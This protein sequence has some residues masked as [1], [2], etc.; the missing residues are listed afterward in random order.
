[1]QVISVIPIQKG[2]PFDTLT[3][4][5]H[6]PVPEGFL[7]QIP[8]Q[9]RQITG[10]AIESR[11]L[12]DAKLDVKSSAFSL[13]KISQIIGPSSID[14]I[15]LTAAKK[16][17]RRS[18]IP[19]GA[20]LGEI[21]VSATLEQRQYL[22]KE[23][24]AESKHQAPLFVQGD[25]AMRADDYRMLIRDALAG[26]QSVLFIA[27]TIGQ[28]EE[29]RAILAKGIEKRSF[30]LHS[31]VTKTE[32]KK[33]YRE[34]FQREG[35][36]ILFA[37]PH[38]AMI[39][40]LETP[41]TILD[42]LSHVGYLS[43]GSVPVDYQEF[44]RTIVAARNK[45]LVLGDRVIPFRY[46]WEEE[47]NPR[48]LFPRSYLPTKLHILDTSKRTFENISQEIVELLRHTD[49]TQ[50]KVFV[51]AERKGIAPYSVCRTCKMVIKCRHCAAS[52]VLRSV[53]GS[54]G[55]KER[56]FLCPE[57]GNQE[58]STYTCANCGSWDIEARES[59]S[60]GLFEAIKNLN[61][62][63]PTLLIEG[64]RE[65]DEDIKRALENAPRGA[66]IIG[67]D[68][69]FS[70]LRETDFSIIP[71]FDRL[72]S[73]MTL[74]AGERTLRLLYQLDEITTDRIILVTKNPTQSFLKALEKKELGKYVE[75][76]K[77][78]ARAL[79]YPP[80]GTMFKVSI[81]TPEHDRENAVESVIAACKPL[82]AFHVSSKRSRPGA[83]YVTL[84]FLVKAGRSFFESDTG[85]YERLV[86]ELS[87][88]PYRPNIEGNPDRVI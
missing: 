71:H 61:L 38:Y 45:K 42:N 11:S 25:S 16:V 41:I 58:P 22:T 66:V 68:R 17:A 30:V 27:P 32:Q 74:G 2:I 3:Y 6:D 60:E 35:A 24:S 5:S 55:K 21:L 75:E 26:H 85:H 62:S 73:K 77:E 67:T 48:S 18:F 49:V 14:R 36:F 1:M 13:K 70:F 69:A 64:E 12:S 28:V 72:L 59:G 7:V 50:K 80:F 4:Y 39:P 37:T 54:D 65:T 76:E 86:A 53:T 47:K 44:Y 23:S 31:D 43:H 81:R 9:S 88:L 46:V 78:V 51:Y 63:L 87:L 34:L 8:L 19:L 15:F 83:A 10:V 84:I 29:W 82:E 40:W 79:G 33:I 52:L 57:C 56:A 20:L